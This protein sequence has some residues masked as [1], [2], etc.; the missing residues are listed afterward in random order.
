MSCD[1]Y[2]CDDC[3]IKRRH[4]D[5]VHKTMQQIMAEMFKLAQKSG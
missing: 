3:G 1:S 5:Y 4:P 2:I